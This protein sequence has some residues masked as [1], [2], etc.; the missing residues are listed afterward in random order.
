MGFEFP[1]R[2]EPWTEPVLKR[3]DVFTK[4]RL[5]PVVFDE[6]RFVVEEIEVTGRTRH[7]KLHDPL[8][9][10]RMMDDPASGTLGKIVAHH[11][12]ES[13]ATQAAA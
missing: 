6:G 8:R 1:E 12:S 3:L 4:I 10:G 7:E 9:F 11:G 13:D 2:F 5:L